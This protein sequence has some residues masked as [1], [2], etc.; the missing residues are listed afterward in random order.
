MI[1]FFYNITEF[2]YSQYLVFHLFHTHHLPTLFSRDTLRDKRKSFLLSCSIHIL[3]G[4]FLGKERAVEWKKNQNKN[5]IGVGQC[6]YSYLLYGHYLWRTPIYYHSPLKP[7][8]ESRGN[9]CCS[10][11]NTFLYPCLCKNIWVHIF[12]FLSIV[13]LIFL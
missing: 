10:W 5:N 4:S 11:Q 9:C 12:F 2:I 7:N 6:A 13:N 8:A 1:V 3:E